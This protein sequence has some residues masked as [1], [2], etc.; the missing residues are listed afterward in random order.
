[1]SKFRLNIGIAGAGISG[2]VAGIELQRAGHQVS[3]YESSPRTGGRIQTLEVGGTLIETGPEFIHGH[4]METL[5][6]LKKYHISYEP[7]HGK[8]YRALE[9]KISEIYEMADGWD[10]FRSR[11]VSV[12]DRYL[13]ALRSQIFYHPV[14]A[15]QGA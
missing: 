15:L 9:G 8:M 5:R 3:I 6:L 10:Q 11:A 4:L 14:K 2:L 1:M 7:I 12:P 13:G